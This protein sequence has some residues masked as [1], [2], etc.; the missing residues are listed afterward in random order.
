MLNCSCNTL[1]Q[2]QTTG[3]HLRQKNE[4]QG[5]IFAQADKQNQKHNVEH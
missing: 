3:Q 5:M 2:C 1:Q 4:L